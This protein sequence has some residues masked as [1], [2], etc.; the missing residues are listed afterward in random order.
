MLVCTQVVLEDNDRT[1]P[2]K[3]QDNYRTHPSLLILTGEKTESLFS[4][5]VLLV[6]LGG[7]LQM[8]FSGDLANHLRPLGVCV[9]G[10][11]LQRQI[12]GREG[13]RGGEHLNCR[14]WS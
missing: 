7:E 13:W 4:L 10:G 1:T 9:W 6:G 11:V 14:P 12:E 3:L 2:E 5:V 8:S